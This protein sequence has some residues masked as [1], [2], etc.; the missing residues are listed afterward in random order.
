M[1]EN[2]TEWLPHL[3]SE[4]VSHVHGS[5]LDA[6]AVSLEGWQR[7]LTLRW[8]IK[9]SEKFSVMETWFVDNPGQLF[10]LSSADRTHYFFRTRGDKVSNQAVYIGKDKSKTK[11]ILNKRGIPVPEGKYFSEIQPNSDIHKYAFSIGFPVVVKSVDGSFGRGIITNIQDENELDYALIY[12]RDELKYKNVILEQYIPGNEYRIY[13]VGNKVVGAINRIPANII[14]D[15]MSSIEILI[16]N[17]NKERM[18]NPRLKSCPININ[19]ELETHIDKLNYDLKS[20]PKKGEKVFLNEKSNISLG[21]DP[22]D[23]LEDLP[24][25]I[26]DTAV[27]AIHAIPGLVHGAV[28]LIIS[29]HPAHN[30]AGVVLEVNPTAQIGSLLYPIKGKGRDIPSEIIDYYFPETKGKGKASNVYFNLSEVLSPLAN[31]TAAITEVNSV[32]PKELYVKKITVFEGINNFESQ[33]FVKKEG[34]KNNLLGFT[35]KLESGATEVVIASHDKH[36]LDN[37]KKNMIEA[38]LFHLAKIKE[39]F[40][41][42]AVQLGFC[43]DGD[44]TQLINELNKVKEGLIK[45]KKEKQI[46]QKQ[47]QKMVSSRVWRMTKPLRNLTSLIRKFVP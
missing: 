4:I 6:Y 34:L 27:S 19:K 10:S 30:G 18:K 28:D 33:Y 35:K 42:D 36:S 37:F 26:K 16:K 32:E 15:G 46:S 2:N 43:L 31:R 21:G 7:G 40:V 38:N 39:E 9:D 8:H 23:T 22:V 45:T 24:V 47:Y 44:K 17:K 3:S 13:I 25:E 1:V 12:V 5:L 11:H 41:N 14:G 20:V 29:N